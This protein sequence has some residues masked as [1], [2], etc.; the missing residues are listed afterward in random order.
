[1]SI[2]GTRPP[3]I[4]ETNLYELHHAIK[5]I[6]IMREDEKDLL[7]K[8]YQSSNIFQEVKRQLLKNIPEGRTGMCPFC[9]ISEPTT[10]D[11][12]FSESEYPEYIIFAPNLV[13]CCSQC[14]SIKGN[15]LFSEN[16]RERKIIHF[17]YD[18]LPQM[19]YTPTKVDRNQIVCMPIEIRNIQ[20]DQQVREGIE[21]CIRMTKYSLGIRK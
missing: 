14:N 3:L 5:P 18:N 21:N 8:S 20:D 15:R 12:Y 1:M 19:Q 11:H 16:Q 4:S 2:I 6:D 9:M 13:P 17:Y 10:F 7:E